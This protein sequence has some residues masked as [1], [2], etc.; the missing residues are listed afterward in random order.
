[1]NLPNSIPAG[2]RANASCVCDT[3]YSYKSSS[4][5]DFLPIDKRIHASTRNET[6]AN[7]RNI[8]PFLYVLI[9]T[10]MYIRI[11]S[12]QKIYVTI[13]NLSNVNIKPLVIVRKLSIELNTPNRV[14][15]EK[16]IIINSEHFTTHEREYS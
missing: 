15:M 3:L 6:R 9:K 13:Q 8:F 2:C 7:L 4:S 14:R 16:I 5:G 10:A 12:S 1:M 11:G